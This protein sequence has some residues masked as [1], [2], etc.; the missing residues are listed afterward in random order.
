MLELEIDFDLTIGLIK[1][2]CV[3]KWVENCLI[4]QIPVCQVGL[5][6]VRDILW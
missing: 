6:Y 1:L 5:F 3:G 4:E 2:N